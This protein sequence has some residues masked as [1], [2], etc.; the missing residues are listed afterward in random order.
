M[1]NPI[2]ANLKAD[3]RAPF[4]IDVLYFNLRS[5]KFSPSGR[6]HACSVT[7]SVLP[8]A[9]TS[10]RKRV[11]VTI[12]SLRVDSSD[13]RSSPRVGVLLYVENFI[14]LHGVRLSL[15]PEEVP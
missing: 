5:L 13:R 10:F 14:V 9:L 6:L 7:V 4:I 2:H 8:A 1:R 11:R 12:E 3:F 15:L